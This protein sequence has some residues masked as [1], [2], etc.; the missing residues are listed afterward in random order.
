FCGLTR[1]VSLNGMLLASPVKLGAAPDLDLEFS[2]TG[3]GHLLRALGRVVREAPEVGWPYV[4]YGVEFLF[5]PPESQEVLGALVGRGLAV[6]D[7]PRDPRGMAAGR[8]RPV[9]RGG[10]RQPRRGPQGGAGLPRPPRLSEARASPS[11]CPSGTR[12]RPSAP[13]STRSSPRPSPIT[14][15]SPSTTAPRTRPRP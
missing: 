15:S 14:R 13:A 8:G 10:G 3:V 5:M 9:L 6:G 12:R 7:P 4:G 1:N 2:V 11:C